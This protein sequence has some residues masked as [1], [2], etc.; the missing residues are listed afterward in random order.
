M[1][2]MTV[3]KEVNEMSLSFAKDFIKYTNLEINDI[4]RKYFKI[5]F[6]LN[7]ANEFEYYKLL[8]YKDIY[9]LAEK[10]FGFKSTTTKNLMEVN[11][12]YSD[13]LM[14]VNKLASST[15]HCRKYSME[16][17][18]RYKDYTQTQLVEMLP[19]SDKERANVPTDFKTPDLRDYKKSLKS[20]SGGCVIGYYEAI[21]NPRKAVEA[22]REVRRKSEIAQTTNYTA[23]D[24]TALMK[25]LDKLIKPKTKVDDVP[26]GQLYLDENETVTEFH[27]NKNEVS[28]STD[29]TEKQDLSI[30]LLSKDD[31]AK[32]TKELLQE[33]SQKRPPLL[34]LKN[35][36]QREDY[37]RDEKN[38]PILVL[39]N[40]ELGITVRRLDFRNGIRVYRT[41]F[42]EYITWKD[43]SVQ[44][45]RYHLIDTDKFRERPQ[46]SACCTDYTCR[47]YT[48]DGT[49]IG[50]IVDYMTKYKDEI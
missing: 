41:V 47:H 43:E 31:F 8:G 32:Q 18:P 49:A 37:I 14:S 15:T 13:H 29:H 21:Q 2:G 12:V 27:L 17:D 19:L 25:N 10:E 39:D 9:E 46:A 11:R 28:Q 40:G 4:A 3:N 34:K 33:E 44:V 36:Q 5:G 1:E 16:I 38:Y 22:V 20:C 30:Y 50:Y 26:Q 35:R 42:H 6:R 7:E 48:L 45:V 23:E 24:H